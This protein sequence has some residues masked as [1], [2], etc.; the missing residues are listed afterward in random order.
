MATLLDASLL[1]GFSAIFAFILVFAMLYGLITFTKVFKLSNGLA[2]LVAF[3][4]AILTVM[5]PT[6]VKVIKVIT[7]WYVLFMFIL[8]LIIIGTYMVGGSLDKVAHTRAYVITIV[9]ISVFIFLAGLGQVFLGSALSGPQTAID[10][11]GNE[12]PVARPY[13]LDIILDPKIIGIFCLLI[14]CGM[15]M[16]FMGLHA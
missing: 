7:P 4:L 11:N 8:L 6:V 1:N 13:F 16:F 12:V 5:S 15:T 3:C 9:T 14:V 2:S 10:I